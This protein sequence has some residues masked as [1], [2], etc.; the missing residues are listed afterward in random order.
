MVGDEVMRLSVFALVLMTGTA[1]AFADVSIDLTSVR[2]D[3]GETYYI[4]EDEQDRGDLQAGRLLV[5]IEAF[6]ENVG[7]SYTM[8]VFHSSSEKERDGVEAY[9]DIGQEGKQYVQVELP[10]ALAIGAEWWL[11][12]KGDEPLPALKAVRFRELTGEPT[13]EANP[14]QTTSAPAEVVVQSG[15]T[16][17]LPAPYYTV[18]AR[19]V[20][21]LPGARIAAIS[22]AV[23]RYRQ[24]HPVLRGPRARVLHPAHPGP[25]PPVARNKA[26]S[27][28]AVV[29]RHPAPAA[30]R[31][32][33]A[34]ASGRH[35][36]R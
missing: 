15:K 3:A 12:I 33:R 6:K 29:N 5:L 28:P 34:G 18:P 14:P 4:V 19:R 20:V 11:D 2:T 8:E 27:K 25:K 32:G 1:P 16:V 22:P 9:F 30:A 7:K 24:A 21:R 23:L 10:A 35:R 17:V 31:A 26:H 13:E 36:G